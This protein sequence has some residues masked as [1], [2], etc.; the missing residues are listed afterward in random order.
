MLLTG[1]FSMAFVFFFRCHLP[2]DHVVFS[3]R[4][5]QVWGVVRDFQSPSNVI[6]LQV[7]P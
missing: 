5:Q 6:F 7:F 3:R 1:S 4:M 2:S